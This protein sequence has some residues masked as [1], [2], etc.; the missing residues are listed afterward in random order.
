MAQ[1]LQ[2]PARFQR[3]RVGAEHELHRPAESGLE[4]AVDHHGDD[5]GHQQRHEDPA[6]PLDAASDAGGHDQDGG[7]HE[8]ARPERAGPAVAQQVEEEGGDVVPNRLS[9]LQGLRGVQNLV[10]GHGVDLRGGGFTDRSLGRVEFALPGGHRGQRRGRGGVGQQSLGRIEVRRADGRGVVLVRLP[11]GGGELSPPA[12]LGR[13]ELQVGLV[14]REGGPHRIDGLG[15]PVDHRLLLGGGSD[16]VGEADDRLEGVVHR[17]AGDH[18]VE[19]QDDEAGDHAEP[20]DHAPA[21]PAALEFPERFDGLGLCGPADHDFG[22]EDGQSD[23]SDAEEV[24]EHEEPA[25]VLARD[26]GELPDVA[27]SDGGTGRRQD[28]AGSGCPV[29]TLFAHAVSPFPG[30]IG[31][32]SRPIILACRAGVEPPGVG[33]I[34]WRQP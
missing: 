8:D 34:P 17:P 27:Q 18:D 22:D 12:L 16:L 14:L 15:G 20:P 3:G 19:G 25:T 7:E 24:D 2:H 4:E 26:V 9:P 29:A 6:G 28:E 10:F 23:Q 21:G 11:G 33:S 32:V 31:P 30:P 5:A 1:G 13:V